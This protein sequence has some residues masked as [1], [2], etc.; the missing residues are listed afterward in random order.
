MF[1]VFSIVMP[2][3]AGGSL[4]MSI[5]ERRAARKILKATAAAN[6]GDTNVGSA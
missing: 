3:G 6:Q 4:G 1:L 2:D 5:A